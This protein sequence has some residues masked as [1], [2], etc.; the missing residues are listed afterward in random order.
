MELCQK[1]F[2]RCFKNEDIWQLAYLQFICQRQVACCWN[3][4]LKVTHQVKSSHV[5]LVRRKPH[6]EKL[7]ALW[8]WVGS[9]KKH[10][11]LLVH[12]PL[13]PGPF[14]RGKRK[15]TYK[16]RK[17]TVNH[18]AVTCQQ[19]PW[20]IGIRRGAKEKRMKR[21][22]NVVLDKYVPVSWVVRL[23]QKEI[24]WGITGL[25]PFPLANS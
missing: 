7:L 2:W 18:S 5:E 24:A 21:E 13:S 6:T 19:N 15:K 9:I 3:F 14:K 11:C 16:P 17:L 12:P 22:L 25:Q 1:Q 4:Q 8:G 23:F 20:K 10:A